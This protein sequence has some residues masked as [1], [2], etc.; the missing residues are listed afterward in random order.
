MFYWWNS[1]QYIL[2]F[3]TSAIFFTRR[4]VTLS[5]TC[6]HQS[7]SPLWKGIWIDYFHAFSSFMK[8]MRSCYPDFMPWTLPGQEMESPRVESRFMPFCFSI[9]CLSEDCSE[10]IIPM[11]SFLCNNRVWKFTVST[12]GQDLPQGLPRVQ[13][14]LILHSP[15]LDKL[16]EQLREHITSIKDH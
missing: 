16:L 3:H 12:L 8:L 9:G 1:I 14:I 10:M 6:R 2:K 4:L 5:S 15:R 11:F 7:P 13:T